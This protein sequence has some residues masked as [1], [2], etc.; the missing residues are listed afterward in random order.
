MNAEQRLGYSITIFIAGEKFNGLRTV[1]KTN[2]NGRG[3]ICSRASFPNLKKR[4]ELKKA[5]IYVLIGPPDDEGLP[6]VY[7]GEGDPVL[8]RLEDH[9]SKKE[10]WTQ[11]VMFVSKD[12]TLNKAKI[13]H[14][15][16]R[17]IEMAK[18]A[19]RCVLDN[20]NTPDKPS[21]SE[22]E[23]AEAEGFLEEL[24][25]CLPTIGV[26][27]FEVPQAPPVQNQPAQGEPQQIQKLFLDTN[28]AKAEGYESEDGFVV[29]KG[30]QAA[31]AE[32]DSIQE[33]TKKM[34]KLLLD[35]AIIVQK[36]DVFEFAQDYPFSSVSRAASVVGGNNVSGRELWKN[37]A[38][39]KLREIQEEQAKAE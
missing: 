32:A 30:S 19:K 11:A 23:E 31:V 26:S 3:L 9:H 20:S 34:R 4:D 10:F 7:I 35:Q 1:D 25:L 13:Q 2:W 16:S 38:G 6:R 27:F 15:E 21:L 14:L 18:S 39:K 28:G 36:G 8:P 5:G 37:A 12:Q 22:A 17:L 33:G 29:T 24:L